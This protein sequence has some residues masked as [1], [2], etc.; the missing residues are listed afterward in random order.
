[1][2]ESTPAHVEG[3]T[4]SKCGERKPLD[5]YSVQRRARD[6]RQGRCKTCNAVD[7]RARADAQGVTPRFV[8]PVG[9]KRCSRCRQV[10][11]VD[12]F[13]YARGKKDGR[14]SACRPCVAE[15]SRERYQN[16]PAARSKHKAHRD[17]WRAANPTYRADY[18]QDNRE[19]HIAYVTEYQKRNP[20][21]R[22]VKRTRDRAWYARTADERRAVKTAWKA[23]NAELAREIQRRGSS[24][25]RARVRELPVEPYTVAELLARDGT[26][27]VLCGYGLNFTVSH[28]HPMAPTI[29][30][31]ECISWLGSAGDAPSNVAMSHFSCNSRRG[32][33]P[34][35]AAS[36]KRAELLAAEAAAS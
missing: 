28:P 31:L 21:P 20:V 29:E 13:G 18:Y 7:W 8:P 25:R 5:Q 30:H 32:D 17:R 14:Q 2:A 35:P 1:M 33:R 23:K 3:K 15:R 6:G 11:S 36:R 12:E 26:D 10:K 4:C 24:R 34:H 16:N 9:M 22:E 27:C 19:K